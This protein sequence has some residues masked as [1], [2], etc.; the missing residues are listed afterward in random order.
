MTQ[1]SASPAASRTLITPLR[2]AER[3]WK[4]KVT[5][6]GGDRHQQVAPVRQRRRRRRADQHVAQEAAAEP[7]RPGQHQH[8][9]DVE[10]LADRRPGAPEI[11]NTKMP[12]RSSTTSSVVGLGDAARRRRQGRVADA[13]G[14]AAPCGAPALAVGSAHADHAIRT[15]QATP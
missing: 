3:G 6:P 1:N 11:A 14:A 12:T 9:E 5:R 7:G 2:A 15:E 10:L 13:A 8:A 4:K